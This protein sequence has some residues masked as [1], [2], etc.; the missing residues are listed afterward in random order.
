MQSSIVQ[1]MKSSKSLWSAWRVL[2]DSKCTDDIDGDAQAESESRPWM[3]NSS[4]LT[5][6]GILAQK[7]LVILFVLQVFELQLCYP[8][9]LFHSQA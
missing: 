8:L 7:G 5:C 6:L 3:A 4:G 1:F 2:Y 9:S